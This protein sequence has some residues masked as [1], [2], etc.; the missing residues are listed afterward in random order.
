MAEAARLGL[1]GDLAVDREVEAQLLVLRL[2]PQAEDEV[3]DLDDHERRDAGE[4]DGR[5]DGDEL[6]ADLA[7][8]CPRSA[9]GAPPIA[10][11]A[12]TPVATAPNMPPTPWTANT[13]SAS[14]MR[15]RSRRSVAL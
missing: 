4:G 9:P 7:R 11:T 6:D 8:G 14:S 10:A 2:D 15:S 5:A 13:S 3:D 1:V 12:K